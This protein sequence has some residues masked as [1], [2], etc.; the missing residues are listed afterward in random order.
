MNA[1][2]GVLEVRTDEEID[3]ALAALLAL[4]DS[5]N[6]LTFSDLRIWSR[7]D[8]PAFVPF[9]LNPVQDRLQASL[10]S[11]NDVPLQPWEYRGLRV[12]V[13]KSRQQ[14]MSTYWL[15]VW[16]LMLYNL[17]YSQTVVITHRAESTSRLW[18][19]VELWEQTVRKSRTLPTLRYSNRRELVRADTG[20]SLF[21]GT[22][23]QDD[24]ARSG[25]VTNVHLTETAF[26]DPRAERQIAGLLG[27]IPVW[28]NIVEEST[29]G[30]M[31]AHQDRWRRE[32]ADTEPDGPRVYFFPFTDTPEYSR[33]PP[34]GF[35]RTEEEAKIV[36]QRVTAGV[37]ERLPLTDGQVYWRRRRLEEFTSKGRPEDMAREFPLTP[38]EAF[39]AGVGNAYFPVEFLQALDA[40]SPDPLR[41]IGIGEQGLGGEV[42]IYEEP[43]SFEVVIGADEAEGHD[44]DDKH[45]YSEA[46]GFRRDTRAQVFHYK[47]RPTGEHFGC[48]LDGLS[49]YYGG[50]LVMVE[51][52]PLGGVTIHTLV[53][54]GANVYKHEGGKE[55]LPEHTRFGYPSNERAKAFRDEALK[56][57]LVRAAAVWEK[58]KALG[59]MAAAA[60]REVD[61]PV[62][63]DRG[64]LRE[65]MHYCNLKGGKRGGVGEHDDGV[66]A[67]TQVAWWL[68]EYGSA[69]WEPEIGREWPDPMYQ[70]R[71]V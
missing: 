20:A 52:V 45:D 3:R 5:A 43:G 4:E 40:E 25:T 2:L 60:C 1:P 47:G 63:R 13:L 16:W 27:T 8:P 59:M 30:G 7:D 32:A 56:T 24:L 18:E 70:R 21:I 68:G 35:T 23:G 39:L 67:C 31:G 48:D 28:A 15:A 42:T 61:C 46:V 53:E 54:R 22:A 38:E 26:W 58:G 55:G 65:L 50:A 66:S 29:S 37:V 34:Q 44:E 19:R 51:R 57:A 17:P 11:R 71:R 6:L 49:G 9:V 62:V 36:A 69:L 64:L 41:V 14:G 12:N 10:M 33:V